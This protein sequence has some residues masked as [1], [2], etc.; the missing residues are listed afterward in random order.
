MSDANTQLNF[1]HLTQN[2]SYKALSSQREDLRLQ[3]SSTREHCDIS[4]ELLRKHGNFIVKTVETSMDSCHRTLSMLHDDSVNYRDTEMDVP[5]P[6]LKPPSIVPYDIDDSSTESNKS[7]ENLIHPSKFQLSSEHLSLHS[8]ISSH[9]D[10]LCT[11]NIPQYNI[12]KP[13]I[14]PIKVNDAPSLHE[15]ALHVPEP[16]FAFH[17]K[18]ATPPPPPLFMSPQ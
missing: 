17:G 7:H 5:I 2:A 18:D 3:N 16:S 10:S 6:K 9:F 11:E 12:N 8:L 4:R 15:P 1:A 13:N 14:G